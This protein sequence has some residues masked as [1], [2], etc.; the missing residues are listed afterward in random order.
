MD[1]LALHCVKGG[2][3]TMRI[4]VILEKYKGTIDD[5]N[6]M[7]GHSWNILGGTKSRQKAMNLTQ[8]RLLEYNFYRFKSAP[9][10]SPA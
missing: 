1:L 2:A 7:W 3:N 9:G 5:V 10:A 8:W 4:L 6:T